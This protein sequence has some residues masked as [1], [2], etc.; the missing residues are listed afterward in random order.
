MIG[1]IAWA[2]A[3]LGAVGVLVL[4]RRSL[5]RPASHGFYRLLAF[6]AIL[7]LVPLN[8]P[9]WFQAPWSPRQLVSWA[10]L[11]GSIYPV[12]HGLVLLRR[13]GRPSAPDP[14]S[15]LLAFEN[16][17]SLV[18]DGIYRFIRHPM[19]ASLLYLAWGTALKSPSP[20]A[21]ALALAAS[22]ALVATAKTE[23]TE[24][25]ARFGPAYGDYM[26][27]T[28]LFVPFLL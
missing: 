16:T 14:A 2:L 3:G 28:R 12:V 21:L 8:I 26:R 6:L 19:Y 11:F 20:L 1:R 25:L 18:T 5:L 24:N 10:L 27:T 15:G 23:E 9:Y 7:A 4:S 17:S 22:A 13:R